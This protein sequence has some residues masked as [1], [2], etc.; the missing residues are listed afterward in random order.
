VTQVKYHDETLDLIGRRV[1]ASRIISRLTPAPLINLYV[2]II[3]SLFSP[4]GLGPF[5]DPLSSILICLAIMVI[6][7]I[8]PIVYEAWK[9]T[10]DLDVSH[11]ESRTKFFI[12]SMMCDVLAYSVY[13]M[14]GC[15][16]MSSLAAAYFSVTLGITIVSQRW[17]I[18]VHAAGVGGPGTALI[19][20]YGPIA[21]LVILVWAAV[22][23]SRVTLKQ[24]NI[25]QSLAGV[26]LSI[27]ITIVTYMILYHP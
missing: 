21:L 12:F 14:L 7:P 18:S 27:L 26:L 19:Y 24:H 4:I 20:V 11:R 8:T 13:S 2:G 1:T 17:K 22:V 6:L 15:L 10:V 23:W 3:L 16:I 9:G 25:E 5:L